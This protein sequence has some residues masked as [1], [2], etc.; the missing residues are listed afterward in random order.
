MI[1]RIYLILTFIACSLPVAVLGAEKDVSVLILPF[2]INAAENL[3]YLQTEVPKVIGQNLTAEGAKV[4]Q[5]TESSVVPGLPALDPEYAR[6]RGVENSADYVL[7]GSL[8]LIGQQFSLDTRLVESF[9]PRPARVFSVSGRGLE[10][11]PLKVR[12]L[13][14]EIV[15]VVFEQKKIIEIRVEGS[16][17]IEADA[18]KRIIKTAPGDIYSVKSLSDDLKAIYAMG[19]FDD[20]RIEAEDD[21]AGKVVIVYVKEKPTIRRVL[22]EGNRVFDDKEMKENITLKT[23]SILNIF[24]VQNNLQRIEELYKDKN[25]HNV[26]VEYKIKEESNNQADVTFEIDE[27]NKVRIEKIRFEGNQAFSDKKLKKQMSTSEKSWLSFITN[28]GDLN[29]ENLDQDSGRLEAFYQ[30]QG[31][32][33]AKVG[34]PQV[35]FTDKGIDVTIKIE[36]GPRYTVGT[37]GVDGELIF[38]SEVLLEKVNLKKEEYYNRTVLRNDLITL[39]DLYADAGYA[40]ADIAPRIDENP[41]ELVV[42][43]VYQIQ[44]GPLVY[45]EE[46]TINGNSSTRD[47]VIRRQLEVYEQGLTSGSRLKR[48]IRNL[49]RLDYFKDVKVNT[50]KGSADDKMALSIDVEEKSTGQFSIGGGYSNVESVFVNGSISQRNLFGRGQILNLSGTIG[51]VNSQYQLSFTEPWLF[52]IPLSG[53]IR[54]YNWRSEYDAY[55]RDSIG[56]SV[57]LGYPVYRD[58]RLNIGFNYD[59][60]NINIT[61]PLRAPSS[62]LKLVEQVGNKD[63]I[64]LSTEATL[65]YDTRDRIFSTTEGALHRFTAEYAG[66]GGDIGFN[67]YVGQVGWYFPLIAKFIGHFRAKAGYVGENSSGVLPDYELFYMQGYDSLVGYDRDEIQPRDARG[68]VIGGDRFGY[69]TAQLI[70]PLLTEFGLDGFIFYSTGAIASSQPGAEPQEINGD[71]LRQSIGAGVNWNSPM[72]P[73]AL[74]YGF[75]IGREEGETAGAWEFNFG[76]SF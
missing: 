48:S 37:V 72:G 3:A 36:E 31:F 20:V 23:G 32:I 8:T 11:L 64:T 25:Y 57:F 26:K 59:S 5:P 71:S 50:V 42:D 18:I 39:S 10:N 2:E 55:D 56:G 47:K 60:A 76:G 16:K 13:T 68:Q 62:I 29:M 17:R 51:A 75:K 27:G 40:Y 52:D 58:T 14:R 22:F 28:S 74:A 1:K 61:E 46:I 43:I 49:N 33:R 19:Y 24:H 30:N 69:A 70:H 44:K 34:E 45:F 53:T 21:P 9:N 7:I 54:L 4:I 66:F 6:R 67:K 63:I 73:I 12:E 38:P 35:V 41:E 15:L 65:T